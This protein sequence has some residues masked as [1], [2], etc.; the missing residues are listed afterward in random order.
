VNRGGIFPAGK[1]PPTRGKGAHGPQCSTPQ[2]A[3]SNGCSTLQQSLLKLPV[4]VVVFVALGR[5]FAR[6]S[7]PN[8]VQKLLASALAFEYGENRR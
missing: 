1:T 4:L 2:A 8:S 7:Q 5:V 6:S 3:L